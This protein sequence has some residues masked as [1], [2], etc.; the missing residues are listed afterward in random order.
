MT[1]YDNEDR[2][3]CYTG[4]M[5][6]GVPKNP[7]DLG[8]FAAKIDLDGPIPTHMPHLGPCWNWTAHKERKGYGT[9]KYDKRTV[10]AHRWS[11]EYVNGPVPSDHLF[12]L[13][14]CDNPTCVNPD[15]LWTG[16]HKDN[17][18]DMKQKGRQAQGE[19]NGGGRKL[20]KEQVSEIRC[21]YANENTTQ[22]Q[23]ATEYGVNQTL[24]G[25]IVRKV[26]WA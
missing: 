6:R 24:I 23:L 8:R 14:Y 17:M 25:F 1:R 7:D 9:F 21:R 26:I 2:E 12:V 22:T 19:D 18:A 3:S 11:F 20:T 5:P 10:L 13:H 16:T 4:R 15:H